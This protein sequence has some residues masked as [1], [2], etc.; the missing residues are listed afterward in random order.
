LHTI[1]V[2]AEKQE[3][4]G[5]SIAINKINTVNKFEAYYASLRTKFDYEKQD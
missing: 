3:W 5:E 1:C 2:F 4:D